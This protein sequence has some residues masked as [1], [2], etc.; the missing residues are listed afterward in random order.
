[1]IEG[2]LKSG[3]FILDVT[4]QLSSREGSS[5][6]VAWRIGS[7]SVIP[8]PGAVLYRS[9]TLPTDIVIPNQVDAIKPLGVCRSKRPHMGASPR[10]VGN[11]LYRI[12]RTNIAPEKPNRYRAIG[13]GR[14]ARV[15]RMQQ[16]LPE[17]VCH[18][19]SGGAANESLG[20]SYYEFLSN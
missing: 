5:R 14:A 10:K 3:L 2:S 19:L 4:G 15:A 1:M 17:R 7:R 13:S 16:Y 18:L 12:Q 11:I 8:V 20:F 9:W 6:L